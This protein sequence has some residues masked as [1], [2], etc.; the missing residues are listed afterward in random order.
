MSEGNISVQL[1]KSNG[2]YH[3]LTVWRREDDMRKFLYEGAH[4]RAIRAFGEI[5]DGKTFGFE[6]TAPPALSEVHTL[7][8]EHGRENCSS[9]GKA[10]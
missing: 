2:V 9:Q 3:T 4:L 5:A 10:S 6:T 8:L 1:T 7:W